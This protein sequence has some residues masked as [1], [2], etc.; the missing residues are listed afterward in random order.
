MPRDCYHRPGDAF[1]SELRGFCSYPTVSVADRQLVSHHGVICIVKTLV[2]KSK[3]LIE[4]TVS[5]HYLL[6]ARPYYRLKTFD[7]SV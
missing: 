7:F 4:D 3:G 5:M 6:T 1:Y 2:T